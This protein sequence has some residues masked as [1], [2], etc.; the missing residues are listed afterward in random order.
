MSKSSYRLSEVAL[1][2]EKSTEAIIDKLKAMGYNIEAA[3]PNARIPKEAYLKLLKDFGKTP[4]S[5]PS[6]P[7]LSPSHAPEPP[8]VEP[9]T[10]LNPLGKIQI[11]SRKPPMPRRLPLSQPPSS[12]QESTKDPSSLEKP[13]SSLESTP[14][15]HPT[16][17]AQLNAPPHPTPAL[18]QVPTPPIEPSLPPPQ[19]PSK[20]PLEA[21]KLTPS[22]DSAADTQTE[23][24]P[25]DET[26]PS[27][28]EETPTSSDLPISI[29]GKINLGEAPTRPRR[30]VLLK[31]LQPPPHLAHLSQAPASPD[32]S[33]PSESSEE[34]T[35][36][37]ERQKRKRPRK[38]RSQLGT[39][40][41]A[42]V[43]NSTPKT[44]P[45]QPAK[46][47]I[48]AS[49]DV[50]TR[51]RLRQE[52]LRQK[53]QKQELAQQEAA[54]T[55]SILDIAEYITAAELAEAL[56]VPVTQ[57]IAKCLELGYPTSI[58]Q[59]LERDLAVIIAEE[60]G[61]QVR[62]IS[63][64]E[65]LEQLTAVEETEEDLVPRPPIVTIMGHVDHGKTTLLDYIRNT[66]VVAGEAG[67]ITQHIGA[68]EVTLPS[69]QKITFLDTPGHEAFTAM[70]A[71]GAQITDIAIIVV[72]ADDHVRPQTLEA[73][74]HA[75]AANVP[76][77]F[78]INKIDKDTANPDRIRQELAEAGFLV[79]EWGGSYMSQLISAKKGISVPELLE[80][81]LI[82]AEL[83]ELKA[84]PNRPAKGAII[85][86]Q[87]D[88]ARGPIATLLV[89]T[90]TL[91]TGDV[92]LAGEHFGKVRALFDERGNRLTQASPSQPVQVLGLSGVPDVGE[93][94]YVLEEE[95]LAREMAHRR[96]ELRKEHER[97][98]ISASLLENIAS[99][100]AKQ[101]NLI[102]KTDVS[103]SLEALTDALVKLSTPE[104]QVQIIHRGVGQI[105]DSDVL[106][107]K[108][109]N[110]LI[111]GFQV[112][113]SHTARSLAK[114]NN[115]EIRLYN[116][117][118]DIIDEVKGALS[119]MLTPILQEETLGTAEVREVFKIPKVGTVAGCKVL[120]GKILRGTKAHLIREGVILYTSTI[121]SLKRFKEDVKE[122]TEGLECGLT[123]EGYQDFK[124]GDLIECFQE[125]QVKRSL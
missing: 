99:G 34:K 106:L 121:A 124:Q 6:E 7:T 74:N 114:Q 65:T 109:S 77:L 96:A 89:Q 105:T 37:P 93:R 117:I 4:P 113:P 79:E 70:R 52:K 115:V 64:D 18:S 30:R 47:K 107:A 9:K 102:I 90:G 25:Q 32:T 104:V 108:A 46:A 75:Q 16:Q 82:M 20:V 125:V 51:R 43:P 69:G 63:L 101:L 60:F 33:A 21:S 84:N 80:K 71:R 31:D 61:F 36:L 38:K 19:E 112:R 58:N 44:Q 95:S 72:A 42:P 76:I 13:I 56:D 97:R 27:A 73:L 66:N 26:N 29:L 57:V 88:K 50:A 68:Y 11:T 67:G 23:A 35:L 120:E 59:R 40:K 39:A 24:T 86:A 15:S 8:E 83:L 100:Q 2:L 53:K 17:E 54:A 10:P 45:K 119:G 94:F 91:K 92:L 85:E 98:R 14:P 48:K 87:L 62:F 110:A 1:E 12:P 116:V 123:L 5:E 78:A 3:S 111:I 49:G 41:A 103:G 122:V 55:A 28:S 81:I 22:S 118:Y